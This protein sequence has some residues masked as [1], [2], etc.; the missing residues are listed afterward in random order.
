MKFPMKLKRVNDGKEFDLRYIGSLVP[1]NVRHYYVNGDEIEDL[2]WISD[3]F[4][5]SGSTGHTYRPI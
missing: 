4:F 2:T 3:N 5:V 1:S